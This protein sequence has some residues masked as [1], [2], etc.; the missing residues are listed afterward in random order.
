MSTYRLMTGD[1]NEQLAM[2]PSSSVQCV[3]TSPPYWK[4]RSYDEWS[5]RI[6]P[7]L[8]KEQIEWLIGEL[9]RRGIHART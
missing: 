6:D 9:S 2:L 8:P 7:T 4:L 1:V 5:V 3:V